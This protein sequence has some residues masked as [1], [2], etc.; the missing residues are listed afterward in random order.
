MYLY[1]YIFI[2]LNLLK[3]IDAACDEPT[4]T[5]ETDEVMDKVDNKGAEE[6]DARV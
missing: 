3:H 2:L 5:E 6:H 4:K 1:N